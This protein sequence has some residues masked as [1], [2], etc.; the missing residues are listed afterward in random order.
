MPKI[1]CLV[2]TAFLLVFPLRDSAAKDVV[3]PEEIVSKRQVIYDDATYDKLATDWEAYNKEFPSEYAYSNW[4]YAAR[5]AGWKNYQKLLE[6]GLKKYPANPKLLYLSA[7]NVGM[8]EEQKR[9]RE[10][11]ERAVALDPSYTDPWFSLVGAY[12]AANDDERMNAAL[13]RLLGSG[14]ITD[15]V[16]DYNYNMLIGLEP[17]ALLITNGDNDTYP[18]W[19]LTRLLNMRSDVT[20]VN[21]SLLNTEWYPIYLINHGAPRFTTAGELGSLRKNIEEELAKK[22]RELGAG[23][24]FGDTL[25]VKVIEAAQQE[26]KPVYFTRT[27]YTTPTIKRFA[28]NGRNLGIVVLVTESSDSYSTQ[29]RKLFTT[30]INLFRTGG[31]DSWRFHHAKSGDAGRFFASNYAFSITASLDELKK[32]APDLRENLFT[33][34]LTHIESLLNADHQKAVCKMW[35]QHQ[36]IEEIQ[37]WCAKQVC[38]K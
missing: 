12:M 2:F 21:R 34:Y 3:R 30:W 4:M 13:R 36:D 23:G 20:I 37:T 25:I 18:G 16:M 35:C 8:G 11:L 22:K 17:N 28:E 24:A 33:W 38:D 5:Y 1:L 15:D 14:I 7:C 27:L 31:M 32:S 10:R 6:K 26:E 19:I 29:L 9:N